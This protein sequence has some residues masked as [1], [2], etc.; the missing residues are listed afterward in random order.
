MTRF[1]TARSFLY[2]TCAI[3]RTSLGPKRLNAVLEHVAETARLEPA[4]RAGRRPSHV[5]YGG[6]HLFTAETANKL[7]RLARASFEA[8]AKDAATFASVVGLANTSLTSDLHARVEA[9]LARE[10]VEA[11]CIDFEDGYGPR[12]DDEEDA[13][14]VRAAAELAKAAEE[15]VTIDEA[16]GPRSV[17]AVGGPVV[18]IRVK[19][20]A[21]PTARRAARTLDLFVTALAGARGAKIPRGF[22]VTLPKVAREAEVSA[23]DE[24]LTMLEE[25]TGLARG[26]IG[27]EL[28]VESPGALVASDGR[29]ALPAIAAAAQGR[30][31]ATHLGAY[32]LTASLGVTA[33]DQRMDHPYCDHA[34]IL[35]QL[36]FAGSTIEVV[37]GATTTLPT[38]TDSTKVRDAWRL[39]AANVRRAL[40]LGIHAGWDLHPAQIP[41]RHGAIHAFYL[42]AKDAMAAR[43][44]RFI[45][46]AARATRSGQVFDDAAT[47]QGLV[48]FF[49]RGIASGALTDDDARKAGVDPADLRARASF[50]RIVSARAGATPPS[51]P[52]KP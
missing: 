41:A 32:D 47:G 25:A 7:G 2:N 20:L 21:G 48:S 24:I 14:A 1:V 51:A 12:S 11:M 8:H 15:E 5:V 10:P 38:G 3:M 4:P 43:L 46:D 49:L 22:T 9:K 36:A 37:D 50:A 35:M 19:S 16:V 31:I 27:V 23:L 40:A 39:H 6:A 18:G 29:L 52:E 26:A 17:A 30:C 45:D 34:R 33:V 13:D 44:A 42:D 28:M